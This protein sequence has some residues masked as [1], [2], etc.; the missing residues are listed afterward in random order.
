MIIFSAGASW[1]TLSASA[2]PRNKTA[3]LPPITANPTAVMPSETIPWP[4]YNFSNPTFSLRYPLG[5]QHLISSPGSIEFSP[6]QP[7]KYEVEPSPKI[8]V[9]I[10]SA[11]ELQ[12][13]YTSLDDWFEKSVR[14]NP[15]R[16]DEKKEILNGN[17]I[18][19]FSEGVAEYP[20]EQYIVTNSKTVLWFSIEASDEA[21]HL[22]L[23]SM[24][25]TVQ[26]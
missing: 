26:F 23:S 7:A 6:L 14:G 2:P 12:S 13:S 10:M 3:P 4:I 20:H 18:Y 24:A 17:T 16:F 9:Q 19:S 15:E 8:T 11:S 5:W 21:M 22:N 25:H 1:N